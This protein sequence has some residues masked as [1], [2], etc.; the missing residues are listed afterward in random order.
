MWRNCFASIALDA[1]LPYLLGAATTPDPQAIERLRAHKNAVSV[2]AALRGQVLQYA[3]LL[4]ANCLHKHVPPC[5]LLILS[6]HIKCLVYLAKDQPG[7]R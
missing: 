5:W 7:A 3:V 6:T 1:A 2:V 4:L